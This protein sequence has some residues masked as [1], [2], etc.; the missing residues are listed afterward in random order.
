MGN[1]KGNA[2][3]GLRQWLEDC[4]PGTLVPASQMLGALDRLDGGRPGDLPEGVPEDGPQGRSQRTG[5]DSTLPSALQQ[6]SWRALLWTA[7]AEARIGRTELCEALGRPKSF[8][9]RHTHC[10]AKNPIPHRKLDG[11]L[12]FVV[13]E[14][15]TWLREHEE[16]IRAG[17]TD[18]DRR[19]QVVQ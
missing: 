3:E 4:P 15:R 8:V 10:K 2:L 6:G 5:A 17:P 7:P 18:G 9:Y 16:I 14:I 12:V 19:V 11:E 13:G 1:G